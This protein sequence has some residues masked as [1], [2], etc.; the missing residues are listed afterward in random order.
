MCASFV[1][2]FDWH[3]LKDFVNTFLGLAILKWPLKDLQIFITDIYPKGAFWP[4]WSKVCCQPKVDVLVGIGTRLAQTQPSVSASSRL[5]STGWPAAVSL[6]TFVL[7][8]S[9]RPSSAAASPSRR[10]T[11]SASTARRTFVF[12]RQPL[13]SSELPHQSQWRRGTATAS[14][15][16]TPT[17]KPGRQP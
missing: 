7:H 5:H 6:L 15:L 4:I 12:A 16:F 11:S 14:V 3:T 17:R 8:A 13:P 1:L 2:T 10:G 9:P